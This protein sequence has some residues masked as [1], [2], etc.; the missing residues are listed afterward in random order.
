MACRDC[1]AMRRRA[2][3]RRRRCEASIVEA[4]RRSAGRTSTS[5]ALR[6]HECVG[7]GGA[8]IACENFEKDVLGSAIRAVTTLLTWEGE[9]PC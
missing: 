2:K 4:A 3:G 9:C 7:R 1:D 5:S 8:R 6:R